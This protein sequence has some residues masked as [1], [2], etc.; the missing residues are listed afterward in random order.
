MTLHTSY[1]RNDTT[2]IVITNDF[3]FIHECCNHIIH[4]DK[5]E[6]A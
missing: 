4:M 1:K 6:C 3:E 5:G 2:I